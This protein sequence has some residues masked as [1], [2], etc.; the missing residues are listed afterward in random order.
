M[1][2]LVKFHNNSEEKEIFG[3]YNTIPEKTLDSF[4]RRA[5]KDATNLVNS[6]D[7][8]LDE[9]NLQDISFAL[10]RA[11]ILG[12]II[13]RGNKESIIFKEENEQQYNDKVTY[14][15]SQLKKSK[16]YKLVK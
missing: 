15:K 7:N 9:K 4:S 10:Y 8:N 5:L 2:K 6:E 3:I 11:Y 1:G 13:E 12:S 16:V 14:R